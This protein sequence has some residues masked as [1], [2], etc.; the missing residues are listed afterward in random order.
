LA[1]LMALRPYLYPDVARICQSDGVLL[2]YGPRSLGFRRPCRTC[3]SCSDR[4]LLASRAR[5][6]GLLV[7]VCRFRLL[8]PSSYAERVLLAVRRSRSLGSSSYAELAPRGP[9]VPIAQVQ[10]LRRAVAP[11]T[12]PRSLG[13]RQRGTASPRPASIARDSRRAASSDVRPDDC[14][15][16]HTSE[17]ITFVGNPLRAYAHAWPFTHRARRVG[18]M[19]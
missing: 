19:S 5:G 1:G 17:L 8:G 12:W 10:L 16:V 2:P 11:P 14:S 6:T 7:A 15:P 3:S 9:P 13:T 18:S 4:R